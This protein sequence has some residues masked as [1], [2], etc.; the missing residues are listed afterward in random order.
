VSCNEERAATTAQR[1]QEGTVARAPSSWH[2]RPFLMALV[3]AAAAAAAVM[4]L[5]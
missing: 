4:E 5:R 1:R 2:W 3:A